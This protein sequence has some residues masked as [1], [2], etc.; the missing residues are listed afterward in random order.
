MNLNC[1]GD[2]ANICQ[3]LNLY[4]ILSRGEASTLTWCGTVA[5]CLPFAFVYP[6]LRGAGGL[7]LC[8]V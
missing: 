8:V 5:N 1:T 3:V 7:G 4:F 2:H 6:P